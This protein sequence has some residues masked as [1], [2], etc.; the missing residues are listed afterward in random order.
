MNNKRKKIL[1]GSFISILLVLAVVVGYA[2]KIK[3]NDNEKKFTIHITSE[4]DNFDKVIDC[5]TDVTTLGD[6]VQTLDECIWEDSEFGTYITGWY[7]IKQDLDNQY[8]WAIYVNDEQ[9]PTGADTIELK[10]GE[11][12]GFVL[13]QGW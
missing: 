1:L 8:W 4:R 3:P 9:S 7:D 10:D 12:Y 5:S 6:Y 11:E 2:T 13:T